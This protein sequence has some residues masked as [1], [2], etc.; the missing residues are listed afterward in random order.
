MDVYSV[1]HKAIC[2]HLLYMTILNPGI[3]SDESTLLVRSADVFPEF[4]VG[5]KKT[6]EMLCPFSWVLAPVD[7]VPALCTHRPSLLP[8]E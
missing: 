6:P 5:V 8:I 4:S 7:Y 1:N 2:S 3:V